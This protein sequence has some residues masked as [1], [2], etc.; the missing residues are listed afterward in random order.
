MWHQF[1]DYKNKC[2]I[3]C[4]CEQPDNILLWSHY[5]DS[6]KGYCVE[7]S[8]IEILKIFQCFL[9]PVIY[10]DKFPTFPDV[11]FGDIKEKLLSYRM[12]LKTITS[13]ASFWAPEQEWRVVRTL[14]SEGGKLPFP[15]PKAIYLGCNASSEL[16][17]DL[18]NICKNRSIPLFKMVKSS[19]DYKLN[20]VQLQR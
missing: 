10:H 15:T 18:K 14:K 1:E 16:E 12:A 20:P 8:S 3:V 9:L 11:F 4:L 5:A 19:A 17:L 2:A 13:K 7:Y 6:H